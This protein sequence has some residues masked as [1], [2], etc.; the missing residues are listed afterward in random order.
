KEITSPLSHRT[1][2]R[3]LDLEAA[4][5][6]KVKARLQDPENYEKISDCIR[7]YKSKIYPASQFRKLVSSLIG[8]HPDLMVACEDFITYIEETGGMRYNRQVFKSTKANGVGEYHD[9][10]DKYENSDL[11]ERDRHVRGVSIKDACGQKMPSYG[12]RE[13]LLLKSIQDLDL[14]NCESCTPSYRLLPDN[15]PMPSAS[16]RTEIGDEVLNDRW[17]SVTSGSEDYSF[18]HMRKNQYEESLFRCEDDRFELDMLLES[19]NATAKCVEE[20]VHHMNA[21][22]NAAD[23]FFID[24]HL[25]ALNLRCIERLYGEHGLD[26]IDVLRRSPHLVLPIVLTRMKQKQEEWARCRADFNKVWAEIYT[27]N[28][29]KSL[30]HRS[31]YF[32]QQDTKNLSAKA[33]LAEIKEMS[34][35]TLTE[36]E[37]AVF[38]GAGIKQPI[39]RPQLEFEYSDPDIHEDLYQLVKYSSGQIC[40][41]D[42]CDKVMKIWTRFLE[43][44]LALPAHHSSGEKNDNHFGAV[45]SS[46]PSDTFRNEVGPNDYGTSCRVRLSHHSHGGIGVDKGDVLSN[47]SL[48]EERTGTLVEGSTRT[49]VDEAVTEDD[50][51]A[52]RTDSS[53]A[54]TKVCPP[55]ASFLRL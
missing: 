37:V 41:P 35:N 8:K 11:K 25:T 1:Y 47:K 6:E 23:T 27:K 55:Y 21:S 45:S 46:K 17:V 24:E 18:K 53:V 4:F 38:V 20:L 9:T 39:R 14:S 54:Y 5:H 16:R 31:F 19:V 42:Q 34:E 28:Y 22:I 7:S 40:T 26:V 51:L 52:S 43:P 33:L 13:K 44:M 10:E 30:D 48:P 3:A 12:G 2:Q 50:A 15:Y 29:H 32:K 49:A 36:D